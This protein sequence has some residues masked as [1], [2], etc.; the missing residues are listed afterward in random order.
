MSVAPTDSRGKY[1]SQVDIANGRVDVT[2]GVDA[3]AEIFGLTVSFTPYTT[4][5]N[6]FVWRCGA[7]P[8]PGAGAVLLEGNGVSAAHLPPGIAERYLPSSCR[9]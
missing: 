4:N 7:A 6:G 9:S 2:F 3:H 8:A 1:V 5:S